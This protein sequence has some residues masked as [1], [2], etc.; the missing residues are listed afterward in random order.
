[1]NNF[2]FSYPTKVYFGKGCVKEYLASLLRGYGPTVMLAYGGGS[3]K[4]S[5]VYDQMIS[6][7][8][9]AGKT[10]VAFG[11]IMPNPTYAKVQ[12]GAKLVKEHHVDF[13]LAVGGGSVID[14][15][16]IVSAQAM[17]DSDIWE[18]ENVKREYP[19]KFI[20]MGAVVTASG[21]GSEMNNGAVITQCIP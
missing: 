9:E 19:T 6:I 20:P 11:G 7:L 14:C 21:T 4:K 3:L 10:V 18:L 5:G 17:T 15:C 12:E 8:A 16:K 2:I 1:M 13:I